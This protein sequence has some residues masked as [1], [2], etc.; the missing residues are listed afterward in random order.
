MGT[1]GALCGPGSGG[2]HAGAEEL[3]R[4]RQGSSFQM[5]LPKIQG[6]YTKDWNWGSDEGQGGGETLPHHG[7][8]SWI[9]FPQ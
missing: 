9:G 8:F 2:I 3:M 6:F 5:V 1:P 4:W 7:N